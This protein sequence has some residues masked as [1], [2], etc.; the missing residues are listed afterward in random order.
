MPQTVHV[1]CDNPKTPRECKLECKADSRRMWSAKCLPTGQW[2]LA[3]L[4]RVCAGKRTFLL[5]RTQMTK[6]NQTEKISNAQIWRLATVEAR[7][8]PRYP[9]VRARH[10]VDHGWIHQNPS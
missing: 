10:D 2:D 3:N 8:M 1:N 6:R 4:T 5:Q 9:L 7:N